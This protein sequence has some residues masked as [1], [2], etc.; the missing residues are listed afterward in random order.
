MNAALFI[1]MTVLLAAVAS[2][3]GLEEYPEVYVSGG[4]VNAIVVV[5]NDAP[6]SY[7]IVQTGI[8]LS[9]NEE[10]GAQQQGVAKLASEVDSLNQN[11]VSIG[12]PCENKVSK[13]ILQKGED[14]LNG[15]KPG[16][17][18]IELVYDDSTKLTHIV[19]AGYTQKGTLEAA[20]KLKDAA[21]NRFGDFT[22]IEFAVDEP[23]EIE[24][25]T[26]E[27]PEH[28]ITQEEQTK[29]QTQEQE[30]EQ[31]QPQPPVEE[32]PQGQQEAPQAKQEN[33]EAEER[34]VF[35]RF[36]AWLASLFG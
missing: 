13:M 9:L 19:A 12:N 25:E 11:T 28:D 2:A 10:A 6:A 32:H 22:I 24:K 34:G 1:V 26:E 18:K 31:A 7:V 30:D 8:A 5:D 29:D 17:A 20:K 27:V 36:I 15:F 35:Q 4:K 14:C 3:H 33:E 16:K 21:H 23:L